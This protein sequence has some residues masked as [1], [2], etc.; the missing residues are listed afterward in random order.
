[1]ST[2]SVL[3]MTTATV[4]DAPPVPDLPPP[5][6]GRWFRVSLY[7]LRGVATLHALLATSQAFTIGRYLDG[8]YGMIR[9][10]S[11]A[12]GLL[13]L[14]GLTLAVVGLAHGLAGGRWWGAAACLPFFFA[15]GVQ[16]G[17]G[18]SRALDIHVPLG[19]AIVAGALA[20]AAWSW[21]RAAGRGRPVRLNQSG[22]TS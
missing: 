9:W 20:L 13:V 10:H 18:Y 21:T 3:G 7:A 6:R 11:T 12:A 16:T 5:R 4:T 17:M 22:A 8:A 15:E 14:L 2:Y 1:L 19:V